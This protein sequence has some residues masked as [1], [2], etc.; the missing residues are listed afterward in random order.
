MSDQ[1]SSVIPQTLS[2]DGLIATKENYEKLIEQIGHIMKQNHSYFVTLGALL[3]TMLAGGDNPQT[4]AD[5][6]FPCF[7]HKAIT[8]QL[9]S[10][11]QML[12]QC[13]K[14][15]SIDNTSIIKSI[16]GLAGMAAK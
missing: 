10:A 5:T 7:I 4:P 14:E 11:D 9:A 8:L 13:L 15:F 2:A 6:S 16:T 1:P 3:A 12:D